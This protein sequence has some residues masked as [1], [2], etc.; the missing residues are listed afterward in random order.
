MGVGRWLE[1]RTEE[2]PKLSLHTV[3]NWNIAPPLHHHLIF[4]HLYLP[5]L[6]PHSSPDLLSSLSH[7]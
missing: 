4:S 7:V 2:E 3:G 6:L 5:L 1:R